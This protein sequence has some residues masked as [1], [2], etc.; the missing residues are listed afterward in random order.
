[1]ERERKGRQLSGLAA[2]PRAMKLVCGLLQARKAGK[3]T[4]RQKEHR[5]HTFI[6]P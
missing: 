1:M 4:S 5:G 3:Q 2:E 6:F